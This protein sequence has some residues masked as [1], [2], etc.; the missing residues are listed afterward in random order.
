MGKELYLTSLL[1]AGPLNLSRQPWER[2]SNAAYA[3]AAEW[4]AKSRWKMQVEVTFSL[5]NNLTFH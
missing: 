3:V 1:S 2:L 4:G 5:P